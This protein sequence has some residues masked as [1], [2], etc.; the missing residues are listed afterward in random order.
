MYIKTI[1]K[2]KTNQ[3][4]KKTKEAKL[5]NSKYYSNNT[6]IQIH[7]GHQGSVENLTL[8]EH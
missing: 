3:T 2:K 8:F 4:N 1:S 5:P 6:R 7:K